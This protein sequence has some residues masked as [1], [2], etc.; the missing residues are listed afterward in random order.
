MIKYC[1]LCNA[2]SD[3]IHF[4]GEFCENCLIKDIKKIIKKE[5][6]IEFCN[7]CNRLKV[8]GEYIENT[9]SNL[10]A[11]M[12]SALD[13][14]R[15]KSVKI[16]SIDEKFANIN[17]TYLIDDE[18]VKF[19]D[20]IRYKMIHQI[21]QECYRKSSGYYEAI[22]QLRGNKQHIDTIVNK[23]QKFIESRGAFI[24]KIETLDN[25][26]LDL[27]LSDKSMMK[28]FFLIYKL[29]PKKSYTLYSI[30]NGKK[31]FR[32]TYFLKFEDPQ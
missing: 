31:V 12:F 32:N 9:K 1:P 17:I 30:K 14:K 22:V 18:Y 19:D 4:I 28:T 27:Y 2:S 16:N 26:G 3:K 15:C 6:K 23:I 25:G 20:I 21:C 11:A 8:N 7:R 13:I 24:S 10:N 29:N 5:V